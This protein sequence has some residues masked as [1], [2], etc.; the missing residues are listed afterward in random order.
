M[1]V[2]IKKILKRL[3]LIKQFLARI[4]SLEKRFESETRIFTLELDNVKK[5]LE[6]QKRQLIEANIIAE[7][8]T[9]LEK[10]VMELKQEMLDQGKAIR[11]LKDIEIKLLPIIEEVS[12]LKKRVEAADKKHEE[13]IVGRISVLE[14]DMSELKEVE[15]KFLWV[16]EEVSGLKKGV[17]VTDQKYER[18]S[19]MMNR[20]FK[21]VNS[22]VDL[23]NKESFYL[24]C[25]GLHPDSYSIALK[26]WYY[27]K[28]F[29]R[30][31]LDAPRTFNEKIQ[32]LKLYDSTQIKTRLADKY[33]VR[34][35]VQ[36]K[37]GDEYLIPLL[38]VWDCFDEIEFD[39][40]PSQFVLKTNHGSA[41]N[42]IVRDKTKLDLKSAKNKFDQWMQKNFAFT[43]GLELHYMNIPRKIIAEQY[44][45]DLDG[46]IY[47]Y[48]VFCFGGKPEYIW[49]D[50]GSGTTN[51]KRNIYDMSWEL[52]DYLV[53][54]PPII[55]EPERPKCLGELAK[56]AKILSE[57]FSF[58]RVDFYVIDNRI[59]FGE[60]TFTPQSG[61]GKWSD[62]NKN[63]QYGKLINLPPKSDIPMWKQ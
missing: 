20:E 54:Y 50:S 11:Y 14:K 21:R 48:R 28:T 40:L 37:I 39:E 31:N 8:I 10:D 47:D 46:E 51:H 58:V 15:P 35:W 32:W 60:M 19:Q 22:R 61:I 42:L 12:D 2:W 55:P 4:V 30:L 27:Q 26:D 9:I 52:Q 7:R 29:Q 5:Q 36:E 23:A 38:G 3:P 25:K 59:F 44:I 45:A 1:R 53:N 62:E 17:E 16:I 43:A 6:I 56:L 41:W 33:L 13:I 34:K 18:I 49:L 57:G 63:L 24:Y